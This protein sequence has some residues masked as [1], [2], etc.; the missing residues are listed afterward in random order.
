MTR[1]SDLS[2]PRADLIRECQRLNFGRIETLVVEDR[3]PRMEPPPSVVREIKL[4]GDN[5]PRPEAVLDDFELRHEAMRLLAILDEIGNGV[6]TVLTV[7]HGLPFSMQL[8][9]HTAA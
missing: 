7:K 5:D 1:L 2:G 6:I 4:H 3:E 8:A 9:E